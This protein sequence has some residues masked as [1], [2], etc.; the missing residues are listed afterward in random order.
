M[1]VSSVTSK[2]ISH[3]YSMSYFVNF[4]KVIMDKIRQRVIRNLIQ[5]FVETCLNLLN[6]FSIQH[7]KGHFDAG[8]AI[9]Y[10]IT[11]FHF[12]EKIG[13]FFCFALFFFVRFLRKDVECFFGHFPK[14]QGSFLQFCSL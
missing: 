2:F 11:S 13:F 1:C 9:S 10:F 7:G 12:I 4:S 14:S 5:R 3:Y 8:K 6:N